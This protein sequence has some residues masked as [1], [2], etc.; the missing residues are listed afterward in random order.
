MRKGEHIPRMQD[1][2]I[3]GLLRREEE[4]RE[5]K[6]KERESF[7]RGIKYVVNVEDLSET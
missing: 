1:M 3:D 5:I 2:S 6:I 7:Q 4:R